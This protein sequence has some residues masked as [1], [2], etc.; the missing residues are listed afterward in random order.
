[1]NSWLSLVNQ[2]LFFT[3]LLLER[4]SQGEDRFGHAEMALFQSA[5]YQLESGYRH[6][7]REVATTYQC[8]TPDT[9]THVEQLVAE[10]EAVDKH[11]A[12]AMEMFNLEQQPESWL[13][14][15]LCVWAS[16]S[17]LPKSAVVAD[18][19]NP[20][21]L[22]QVNQKPQLP[23]LNIAQIQTW[24]DLMQEMVDRHREL[25]VEC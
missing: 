12:E 19:A 9:I 13:A 10:L 3:R 24:L 17:N 25:M 11:P 21:P 6:H 8:R 5:V 14:Q 18:T 20:I 23:M 16:F 1:M 4:V 15:L 22:M 7:L 2:K